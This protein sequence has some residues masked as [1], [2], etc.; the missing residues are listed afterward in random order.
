MLSVCAFVVLFYVLVS[1]LKTLGGQMG[2]FLVGTVE[3]FSLTPLLTPDRFGYIL[4]AFCTGWGG[5]SVLCQTAAVLD[6]SDLSLVPCFQGKLVQ[7]LL[8]ALLAALVVRLF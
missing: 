5:L 7:G 3:L 8:S 2:A 4:A 1:P 6:E